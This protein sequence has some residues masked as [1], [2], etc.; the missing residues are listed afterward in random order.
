MR[1]VAP[2]QEGHAVTIAA[3]LKDTRGVRYSSG[4]SVDGSGE[5]S[6]V[7]EGLDEQY[8]RNGVTPHQATSFSLCAQV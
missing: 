3:H 1:D 5:V 8:N 4:L 6:N 2:H 7:R